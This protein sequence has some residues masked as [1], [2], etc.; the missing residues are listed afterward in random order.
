M[1][2]VIRANTVLPATRTE[3]EVLTSD[4]VTLVVKV[5]KPLTP[6][7]GAILCFHPLPTACGM[8]DSHVFKKASN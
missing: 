1:T 3:F 2:E 7:R 6:A 5:A 4:G 8:M